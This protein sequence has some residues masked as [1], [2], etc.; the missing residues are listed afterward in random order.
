MSLVGHFPRVGAVEVV[1]GD[2]KF[3]Y[4]LVKAHPFKIRTF[5]MSIKFVAY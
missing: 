2:S 1:G 3:T 4:S 5:T